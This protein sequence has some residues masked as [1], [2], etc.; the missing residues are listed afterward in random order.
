MRR[1]IF[2]NGVSK[3]FVYRFVGWGGIPLKPK[4]FSLGSRHTPR[5]ASIWS[6]IASIASAA[7]GLRAAVCWS[8][9]P[10]TAPSSSASSSSRRV[11]RGVICSSAVASASRS[12][13]YGSWTACVVMSW[14]TAAAHAAVRQ[15]ITTHA[16]QEP[17]RADLEALA[18]ALEQITPR[19]TRRL[20]EL[21]EELGAVRGGLLQQTAARNPAAAEAIDAITDQIDAHLGV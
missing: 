14:R 11:L 8:R 19:S 13:R 10:L 12:A 1:S 6:V 2:C 5:W 16:V 7:A 21:A 15:L 20:E 9:P 18:T 4:C 3:R 17:Y